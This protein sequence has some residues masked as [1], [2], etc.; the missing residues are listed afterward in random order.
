[1]ENSSHNKT[2]LLFNDLVVREDTCNFRC[3]Y[4]L[5]Y[6]SSLKPQEEGFQQYV[7]VKRE[8]LLYAP[9]SP[10]KERLD[11]TLERF[12]SVADAVILR[13]S[14]GEVLQIRGIIDF[15]RIKSPLYET[16]QIQTNGYHLDQKMVDALHELGNVHVLMSIDGH[17]LGLNG[18]RVVRDHV[19]DRLN[20]NLRRTIESGM[21]TDVTSVLSDKNMSEYHTFLDELLP[22]E[23]RVM[24]YPFPVRGNVKEKMLPSETAIKGFKKHVLDDY[25]KYAGVLAP[26]PFIEELCFLL[27]EGY[28]RLR[29]H[30]PATMIQSFDDGVL[31]PC[32]NC[33]ATELGNIQDEEPQTVI[34]RMGKG[35]IYNVFLQPKPRLPFCKQCYTAFDIVNLYINGY[36]DD[37][38][39]ERIPSLREP[40][41][42]TRLQVIKEERMGTLKEASREKFTRVS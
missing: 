4:C 26:K 31:T 28:R 35:K 33:W 39:I 42:R 24:V 27:T 37:Q 40:R 17:T 14:G 19:Q 5:S 7:T 22:Y 15:F 30:V 8:R 23:G 34:D 36:I 18:Y 12:E 20:E 38:D 16:I 1:M 21:P 32:P 11:K 10:L 41:A 9:G 25:S 13:V 2:P 6:E 3:T 29:C